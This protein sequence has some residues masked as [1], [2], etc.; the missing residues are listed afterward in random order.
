M[1]WSHYRLGLLDIAP[2]TNDAILENL[3]DGVLAI[4]RD[5]RIL[6]VNP[7]FETI[8][9][10]ARNTSIGLKAPE[11]LHNWPDIFLPYEH[12]LITEITVNLGASKVAFEMHVSHLKQDKQAIG[13]IYSFRNMA[14]RAS[15]A[16]S[17][18]RQ[19]LESETARQAG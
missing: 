1:A 3:G 16:S 13:Y 17:I 15:V 4:D 9:G 6:Y 5:Q 11:V 12:D 18:T 7:A 8:A 2:I 10:L 14:E 19:R